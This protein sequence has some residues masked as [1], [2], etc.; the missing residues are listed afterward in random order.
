MKSIFET[1]REDDRLSTSVAMLQTGGM[2]ETL[3]GGGE[4]TALFPT[5]EAYSNFSREVLDAITA[6]RDRLTEMIMYH[7]IQGKLTTHELSRMEAIRTLQGDHLDI[8]GPPSAIRLNDAGVIQPDVECTNGIYHV[9][10]RV[11]LPRAVEARVK[12]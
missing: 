7:V 2:A 6:D 4:Y 11:L 1:A 5:N 12:R 10:D 3:R 8:A 9:I